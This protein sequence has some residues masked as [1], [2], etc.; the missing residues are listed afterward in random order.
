MKFSSSLV[1][2]Y[3]TSVGPTLKTRHTSARRWMYW[4]RAGTASTRGSV[5]DRRVCPP[6]RDWVQSL[7][8]PC[9]RWWTG[10]LTSPTGWRPY[11]HLLSVQMTMN[12]RYKNYRSVPYYHFVLLEQKICKFTPL[13]VSLLPRGSVHYP[14]FNTNFVFIANLCLIL[15]GIQSWNFIRGVLFSKDKNNL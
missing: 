14:V 10:P 6:W 7:M 9:S 13:N 12:Y 11:P 2:P 1:T 5:S 15:L 3:S 4:V 8:M